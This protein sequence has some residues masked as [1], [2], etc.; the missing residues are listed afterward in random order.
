MPVT[1][2]R[3][4]FCI[5]TIRLGQEGKSKAQIASA[6]GVSTKTLVGWAKNPK[7]PEFELALDYA[8]T[9]SQA[10]HEDVGL[11]GVKGVLPKFN[12]SAWMFTMKNR[13]RDDY[14]DIT[15]QNIE[16]SGTAKNMSDDELEETIKALVSKKETP[17][18][19]SSGNLPESSS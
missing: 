6:L 1:T 18:G 10:Y 9:C 14:K 7:F 15:D 8:L 4:E 17:A 19:S 13:F 16:L 11:K 12:A 3:P 5:E 2:Y